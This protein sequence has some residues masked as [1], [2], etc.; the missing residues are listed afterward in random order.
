MAAR[1]S[2]GP[3]REAGKAPPIPNSYWLPGGQVCAGEY[4]GHWDA[5]DRLGRLL[6]AGI[7]AFVDLTQ[8]RDGLDP[9]EELVRALAAERGAEV[10]CIRLGVRD[11]NIPSREEMAVILDHI[12][13]EVEAGRLVYVHCWG[14]IGRTGT[15][16]GCHLVRRGSPG[17]EA[18]EQIAEFWKTVSPEKR[19]NFPESPQTPAQRAFVRD[20]VEETPGP[21]SAP[22]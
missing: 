13:A 3:G 2:G 17:E 5:H 6:D 15:V 10:T 14:G 9:Y 7:R 12:D 20:W 22:G 8:E 11:L 4:P 18:L 19:A 21:R 16:V 1:E